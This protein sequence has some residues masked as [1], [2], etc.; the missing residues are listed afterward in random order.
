MNSL[1]DSSFNFTIFSRLVK[2]SAAAV[3]EL[4]C[5]PENLSYVGSNWAI[6]EPL[7]A[8][9]MKNYRSLAKESNI[10]LSLG[11]F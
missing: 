7:N 10:W 2:E 3:A 6:S 4:L 8:P 11:E 9:S 1:N 5:F